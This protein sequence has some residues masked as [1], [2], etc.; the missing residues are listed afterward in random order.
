MRQPDQLLQRTELNTDHDPRGRQDRQRRYCEHLF[1]AQPLYNTDSH[2]QGHLPG[3]IGQVDRIAVRK[4]ILVER[5]RIVQSPEERIEPVERPVRRVIVSGA[6]I[7]QAGE[8]GFVAGVERTGGGEQ[9]VWACLQVLKHGPTSAPESRRNGL[10]KSRLHFRSR[11][12]PQQA[13]PNDERRT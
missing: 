1:Y 4:Q 11:D 6:E 10:P 2:L 8:A 5:L 7:L 3:G 13:A 9:M 12:E